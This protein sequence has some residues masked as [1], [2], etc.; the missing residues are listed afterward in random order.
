MRRHIFALVLLLPL[1]CLSGCYLPSYCTR[2]AR[3]GVNSNEIRECPWCH[4][5]IH[6]AHKL[7]D[8]DRARIT[9][10]YCERSIN[11]YAIGR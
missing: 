5:N 10:P 1:L 8:T 7:S 4:N 9:C 3:P 6:I 2:T 11:I